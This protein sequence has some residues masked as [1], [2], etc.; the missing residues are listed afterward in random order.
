MDDSRRL[1]AALADG[2][3]NVVMVGSG[4]IGMELAAAASA[5][6]N[7][8]TLLGLEEVPLGAAIGPELGG[9]FRSLHEANGVRFRLPARPPGSAASRAGSPAWSRMPGR[10]CPRT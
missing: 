7:S 4:W 1:R 10:S 6:G 5:Y 2:G 3:R 9:F 8:V